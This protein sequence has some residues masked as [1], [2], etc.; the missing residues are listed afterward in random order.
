[1]TCHFCAN[2]AKNLDPYAVILAL[3]ELITVVYGLLYIAALV[4]KKEI[5]FCDKLLMYIKRM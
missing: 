1:M 3:A 2:Y 5:R 4:S